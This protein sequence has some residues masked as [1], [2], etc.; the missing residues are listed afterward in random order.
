MQLRVPDLPDLLARGRMEAEDLLIRRARGGDDD[1]LART[2][3]DPAE[4]PRAGAPP[5]PGWFAPTDRSGASPPT[6][7]AQDEGDERAPEE[8]LDPLAPVRQAQWDAAMA[9]L[10]EIDPGNPNLTDVANPGS[11]PSQAALDRLDAAV[12]AAAIRR[13]TDKVMPGGLPI[14]QAG[15]STR[16]RELPGGIGAAKNLFDY[17]R[18]GGTV[19]RSNANLTVVE[20][21]SDLGFITFRRRSRSASPAVDVNV[22][23]ISFKLIHF[24]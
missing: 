7:V 19:S 9:T 1:R 15:N 8:M 21:P 6:R 4:H 14:G 5:N 10:R 24:Y 17:L 23:G 2:G 18:V 16:I 20:L 22:P 12:K 11:A 3:W 13:V